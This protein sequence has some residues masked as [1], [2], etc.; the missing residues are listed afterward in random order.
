[1]ATDLYKTIKITPKREKAPPVKQKAYRGFSTVNPE[2]TTFQQFDIG[3]IK[4]NLLNH[5]NIRQGEK[6]SDPKFGC[7]IWDALYEPLTTELKDA[8]TTN[9]TNIVNYDPRTRAS[10]VQVSEYE[11]GLQIEATIT[12]RDYNISEN[13]RMQFDK[14]VGLA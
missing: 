14:D 2:S 8:I 12:Y 13:L 6:L 5:F 1:M 4:Q 7:I 3:L 10:G 11:S 9:V